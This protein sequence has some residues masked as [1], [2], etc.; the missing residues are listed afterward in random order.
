MVGA[1][2]ML[3]LL[4]VDTG[5]MSALGLAS[6]L[7]LVYLVSLVAVAASFPFLAR[8]GQSRASFVAGIVTLT[9]LLHGA[10]ALAEALPRFPT[11]YLHVGFTDFTAAGGELLPEMD[12]RYNW[13]GFFAAVGMLTNAVS[14]PTSMVL[15]KWWP[16]AANLA[17]LLPARIV[18]GEILQ[19]RVRVRTALWLFVLLNWVGQD[20]FSPQSVGLLLY[21]TAIAVIL[22]YR[23]R[24]DIVLDRQGRGRLLA[25][26]GIL[27]LLTAALAVEHQLTPIVAVFA[28]GG[29]F[30]LGGYRGR[31]LLPALI[32]IVLG[33]VSFGAVDYW[34]GHSEQLLGNFG[35]FFGNVQTSVGGRV[36]GSPEHLMVVRLRMVTALAVWSVAALGVVHAFRV[37]MPARVALVVLLVAPFGVL[38]G[39]AYGGEAL[40]RVY[41]F[42]L[43][44]SVIAISALASPQLARRRV[45][46]VVCAAALAAS[47]LLFL[48]TRWGNESYEMTRTAELAAVEWLYREAP[49]GATFV[50]VTPTVPWR[51]RRIAD[52]RYSP[53]NMSEFALLDIDQIRAAA[54]TNKSPQ[55]TYVLVTLA[56]FAYAQQVHGLPDG[57][58]PALVSVLKEAPDMECVYQSDGAWVF[59][60]LAAGRAEDRTGGSQS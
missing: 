23:R 30:L 39:Q 43:L 41:A 36:V 8:S 16:V 60:S 27:V 20:Y 22:R 29:L 45:T 6:V 44:P 9:F 1:L 48:I 5:A 47:S 42:S 18:A 52:L 57:W 35:D 46:A 19:S 26:A 15:L 58:G 38:L 2:G 13:P 11:A 54:A 28:A 53:Y 59:Q 3:S 55:P 14:L 4:G 51:H 32:A 24:G 21:L 33:W 49:P 31:Y 7:P 10:P 37:R 40:L 56:Q 12:A 17:Y 34:V 50:S 25:S